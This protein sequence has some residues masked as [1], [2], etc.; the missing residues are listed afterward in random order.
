MKTKFISM[1]TVVAVALVCLTGCSANAFTHDAFEK[2]A[3]KYGMREMDS[4]ESFVNERRETEYE[5]DLFYYTSKTN[6]E[7][8]AMYYSYL[9]MG[10]SH[11]PEIHIK[12]FTMCIENIR[13]EIDGQPHIG[14]SEIYM[15]TATDA[16]AAKELYDEFVINATGDN[17][18]SGEKNGYEYAIGY[19]AASE[20]HLL[21]GVYLKDNTVIYMWNICDIEGG[22]SCANSFCKSL[23]LVSPMTLKNKG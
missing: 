19:Q 2:A 13:V 3:R 6:K 7:A 11:Y 9:Q 4:I 1:V 15:I 14:N 21:C 18:D 16:G 10:F 5:K 22:S 8:D 23:G 12:E 20:R 17:C